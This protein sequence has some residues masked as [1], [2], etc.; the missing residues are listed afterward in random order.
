M[1]AAPDDV[2]IIHL[3]RAGNDASA[4]ARFVDS[5]LKFPAGASHRLI[6]LLKGFAHTVPADL[7]AILDRV[8]HSRLACPDEGYDIGSYYH[9]A[10]RLTERLLVFFNSF[11]IIGGEQWLLKLL[12]GYRMAG[13]GVV[14]ASGSWESLVSTLHIAPRE[15]RSR[16][17]GRLRAWLLGVPL[18]LFFP[19]FPNPHLRSNAF[20]I[21][22]DDFLSI[23]PARIRSKFQ[24]WRFESGRA[25]MTRRL[26]Q[27]GLDVRVIGRD[28][29]SY[30]IPAW[31]ESGT[32]WQGQQE[33]L[34]VHDNRSMAYSRASPTAQARLCTSAWDC[35]HD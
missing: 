24:A 27:R 23:R 3:V 30:A 1:K 32:F 35:R 29:T 31:S 19:A 6:F 10:D 15:T 33:N 16:R 4:T 13:V 12:A 28:G 9:A 2:A 11:S 5:Y 22:R 25:S 18:G 8:P 21:A 34:L 20:L 17:F 14:G 7:E 26:R